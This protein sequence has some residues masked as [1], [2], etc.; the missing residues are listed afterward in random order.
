MQLL[1]KT[2]LSALL[3]LGCA[4]AQL[5]HAQA[6]QPTAVIFENVRIFNGTSDRLSAPS[7]VMVVGNAIQSISTAPI[8]TP[9]GTAVIRIQCG[10]R[11]LMP[12]M[13][14]VHVHIFMSASSQAELLD[15]KATFE[16]LEAKGRGR[17]ATDAATRFHGCPRHGRSGIWD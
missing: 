17:S 10:G 1:F 11:A 8:A 16:S 14:D 15:P 3:V 6:R 12:G 7:N 13:S 9:T 2:Q 4:I 5:A